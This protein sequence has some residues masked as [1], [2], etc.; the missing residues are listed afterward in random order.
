M[1][2]VWP[3]WPFYFDLFLWA[4]GAVP[5][6][7][8]TARSTFYAAWNCLESNARHWIPVILHVLSFFAPW[9]LSELV[10]LDNL[11]ED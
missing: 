8:G 3:C 6:W 1:L 7:D 2:A 4:R 5:P 10:K 11:F 9:Q